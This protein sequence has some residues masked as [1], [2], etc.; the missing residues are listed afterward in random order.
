MSFRHL[1]AIETFHIKLRTTWNP[2]TLRFKRGKKEEEGK[3][4][5]RKERFHLLWNV[6]Q[7]PFD[8]LLSATR[9]HIALI[10]PTLWQ[11]S[12]TQSPSFFSLLEMLCYCFT[13][14]LNS[15]TLPAVHPTPC[16]LCIFMLYQHSAC[17]L[18]LPRCQWQ[19]LLPKWH[20]LKTTG[21]QRWRCTCIWSLF[22]LSPFQWL[23]FQNLICGWQAMFQFCQSPD[24]DYVVSQWY[25]SIRFVEC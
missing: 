9:W 2:Q 16:P 1:L 15:S 20:G 21:V 18:T 11:A 12:P 10:C 17:P 24:I 23:T 4:K 13:V 5:E 8:P 7:F 14:S 19:Y 3:K 25:I 22:L 6:S